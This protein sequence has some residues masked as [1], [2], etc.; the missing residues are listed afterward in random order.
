MSLILRASFDSKQTAMLFQ[1]DSDK[2]LTSIQDNLAINAHTKVNTSISSL[3]FYD[4]EICDAH[5]F[6]HLNY[7]IVRCFWSNALQTHDKVNV[8]QD[9]LQWLQTYNKTLQAHLLEVDDFFA[10]HMAIYENENVI[11][12]NHFD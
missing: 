2:T 4:T 8:F 3:I 9:I 6:L 1:K 11:D 10:W 12:E 7:T 5:M